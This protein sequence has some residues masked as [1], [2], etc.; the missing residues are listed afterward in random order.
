[1]AYI[2]R[3]APTP[4]GPLH[5]GSL[6]AALASFLDARHN[7]GQWLVRI[8]DID[9]PRVQTGATASILHCLERHQLFWDGNI[10]YQSRQLH[11]Y[12][13]IIDQW[14][15]DQEAYLCS[16][17]RQQLKDF[18]IYPGFCRDNPPDNSQPSAVRLVTRDREIAFTDL[19]Q[20]QQCLNLATDIGDFV[21]RR[22]DGLIAYQLAV[23]YDD[24]DQKITRVIRGADLLDSSFKQLYILSLLRKEAPR[25]GHIPL[26][27]SPSGDKLSK[28]E[29]AHALN[30]NTPEANLLQALDLL[31]QNPPNAILQCTTKD[32]LQWAIRHWSLE[33]VPKIPSIVQNTHKSL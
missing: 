17:S 14:L 5:M 16:C 32:I 28:Q 3:F 8:E 25:Y 12:H 31:G 22:K 30:Q 23:A 9:P 2:G 27:L 13:Q 26:I 15:V 33:T 10:R 1:M 19:I 21:V 11:D 7:Q 18:A 6:T 20:N 4:S 24:A 29:S